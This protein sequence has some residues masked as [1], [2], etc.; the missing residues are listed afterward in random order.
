MATVTESPFAGA[1]AGLERDGDERLRIAFLS[2]DFPEYCLAIA[3]ALAEH[4]DVL[5]LLPTRFEERLA[6]HVS[7]AVEV[8]WFERARLRQAVRQLRVGRSLL[9]RIRAFGPDVL[10]VQQ[11]QLWWNAMQSRLGDVPVV[12]TV[13]NAVHH[14][15]DRGSA[16]TPAWVHERAFRRADNLIVHSR[17]LEAQLRTLPGLASSAVSVVPHVAIGDEEQACA[18]DVAEEPETILFFGR[19]WLY[20]GLEYLIRAEPLISSRV[21]GLRI[22]IAGQGE[23]FER[24][25][26]MMV[27]PER[28]EVHNRYVSNQERTE[29]FMR[30]SLVV[31]PYIEASQSGVTH[32]AFALGKPVVATRVG[33]LPETIEHGRT[34][35]LVEPA[36]ERQLADAIVELLHDP[37][38][39][40]AMGEA[41]RRFLEVEAAPARVA[42]LTRDAYLAGIAQ[43]RGRA[44]VVR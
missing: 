40:R 16:K 23:E 18:E 35:L 15:G 25:R 33:A 26:R 6:A 28:F 32:V 2:Y 19:I 36:D 11:G 9:R 39:R 5:L 21:P 24:Y 4:D 10:H 13:H 30:S 22:V 38:R 31:L 7:P 8:E 1:G 43:S 34:G 29:F 37:A 27:H 42:S 12:L 44:R 14:P 20:K 17:G 3:N 41:A